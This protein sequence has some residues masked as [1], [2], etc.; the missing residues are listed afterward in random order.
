MKYGNE[1]CILPLVGTAFS[2]GKMMEAVERME[3]SEMQQIA[4]AEAAYFMAQADQ[5]THIVTPFLDS[6]DLCLRLSADIL[7]VFSNLTLGNAGAAQKGRED[8]ERMMQEV[9]KDHRCNTESASCIFAYYVTTTFLHISPSEDMPD[10]KTAIPYLPEGQRLF[11]LSLMA[12]GMYLEK[13]YAQALGIV[14]SAI[15]MSEYVYPIPF[16][17]LYCVSAM[18]RIN[19][20]DRDGAV[21]AVNRAIDLARADGL[22]EPFIEYHGLLQGVLEVCLRKKEPEIYRRMTDGII[23]FSRGWMKIH[24]PLMNREVTDLLTPLEFS[25][26][27]LACR[28]WT[29]QE[30]GEYLSL[31]TNTV[32]HYVSQILDKLHLDKREQLKEFVNQ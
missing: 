12:H 3:N 32:K 15:L 31:S 13:E 17:Y 24:N 16:I 27:M 4:R 30:I 26:A 7:Y 23:A 9:L 11:A 8:V 20:K 14:Q 5:C 19:M 29:N 28:D 22:L 1:T 6:E 18:C 10:L 25:I 21:E 2:M